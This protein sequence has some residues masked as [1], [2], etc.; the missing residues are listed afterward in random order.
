LRHPRDIERVVELALARFNRV[1]VLVNAAVYSVWA[2]M[3]ESSPDP[4]EDAAVLG[5]I[6]AKP[7][8]W[9]RKA[10]PALT[11]PARDGGEI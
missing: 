8:G 5:P 2:P 3:L 11:G 1:D 4:I 7:F 6:K 9:P 10:R